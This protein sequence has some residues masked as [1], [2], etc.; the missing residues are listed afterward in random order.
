MNYIKKLQAENADLKEELRAI[1]YAVDN[2]RSVLASPKFYY[3]TTI[4]V[5]DVHNYLDIIESK[6]TLA[7]A[8]E[9]QKESAYRT[10]YYG[11]N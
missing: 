9:A 4:Q 6:D 7:L 5:S 11:H 10:K 8:E 1:K 3:D 2:F